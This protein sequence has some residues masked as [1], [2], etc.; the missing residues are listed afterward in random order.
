[1]PEEKVMPPVLPKSQFPT[2]PEPDL[3][4][5]AKRPLACPRSWVEESQKPDMF[6]RSNF[7]GRL[8]EE[9]KTKHCREFIER[10][11]NG[12][13]KYDTDYMKKTPRSLCREI[14]RDRNFVGIMTRNYNRERVLKLSNSDST[15][16]CLTFDDD[17]NDRFGNPAY[18]DPYITSITTSRR[19]RDQKLETVLLPAAASAEKRFNR[20]HEHAPEYGNFS[21]Y[22]S[23]I[24][25]NQAAV[26]K[27]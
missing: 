9:S 11:Q 8:D 16:D 24:K 17:P 18:Q 23:V 5:R 20:G 4:P 6:D 25:S 27:R 2:V 1:V 19:T 26:L 14:V 12:L 13:W 10:N 21:R 7:A 3:P 15:K 22:N